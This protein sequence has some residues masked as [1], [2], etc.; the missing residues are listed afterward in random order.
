MT[1]LA[2]G[3]QAV[4]L[5][6]ATRPPSEPRMMTPTP[7]RWLRAP[8]CFVISAMVLLLLLDLS[9][10][11]SMRADATGVCVPGESV[12]CAC[13]DGSTSAQVCANDG[14]SYEAC[15]CMSAPGFDEPGDTQYIVG[16]EL[17]REFAAAGALT[18][19]EE[20]FC[21]A[22]LITPLHALTAAHCV[23][24]LAAFEITLK[25]GLSPGSPVISRGV[26]RIAIHPDYVDFDGA[27]P[28]TF[29]NGRDLAVLTLT[30]PVQEITPVR[31]YFGPA[32]QVLQRPARLIGYGADAVEIIAGRP[33]PTGSGIRRGS[34]VRFTELTAEALQYQFGGMG[35]CNGDSGGPAFIKMDDMWQQV[36]VTS[37]GDI[38]CMQRG[39]YQR[40]D[41]HLEWLRGQLDGMLDETMGGMCEADGVCQGSCQL[42][43]DCA[44]LLC[45]GGSCTA[46]ASACAR[47]G[48]C[49]AFCGEVDADC[50]GEGNV[51]GSESFDPC[52]AYGLHSN[53]RCDPQCGRDPECVA[54][55]MCEPARVEVVDGGTQC[56][57]LDARGQRC[58]T[59]PLVALSYDPRRAACVALDAAGTACG[60]AP[61]TLF[62]NP[63]NNIC[64]Y[65]DPHGRLCA[66][67]YPRCS[68]FGDCSC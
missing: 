16:G 12:S 30:E 13:A 41:L 26:T 44:R 9:A 18:R 39:H 31:L 62:Y 28:W 59:L 36:G 14:E 51:A 5:W 38:R 15:A 53:G 2:P 54:Q 49:E 45:P 33:T 56:A 42:D 37:W 4:E 24:Q 58:H 43:E 55:T 48:V 21:T 65:L 17:S 64:S 50:V 68:G 60:F 11:C 7:P 29:Q 63:H 66:Q 35:A 22:T 57:Y 61:A 20:A 47:D 3:S 1:L 52:E 40:L 27:Q 6:D 8:T 10:G 25:L 46:A 23:S 19:S 67:G 32:S 34:T